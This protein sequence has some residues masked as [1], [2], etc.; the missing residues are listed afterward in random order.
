MADPFVVKDGDTYYL[1]AEAQYNSPSLDSAIVYYYSSDLFN[2]TYGGVVLDDIVAGDEHLSYPFVFKCDGEWY[3]I[4]DCQGDS[5]RLFKATNFPTSWKVYELMVSGNYQVRDATIFQWSSVWYL[6]VF[7]KDASTLR[8]YYS[9]YLYG[10]TW[11]EHPS[12]PILSGLD[13]SR[14]G[15]RPIIRDGT[16]VDI[17]LQDD[18]PSY[19]NALRIYRLTDLTT[20]TC[21]PTELGT[22]PILSASGSGWNASGMHTLDRIDSS[23]SI[24][25]GIGA[26]VWS[27]GIYRDSA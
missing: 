21:T 4:P 18:S 15:G 1:F 7:D 13:N 8:L 10:S 5:V 17:L 3:M 23:V 9:S 19:G 16:G 27:I 20:T 26:G 11:I 24:V 12:S 2:W 6:L 22:S 14:P 25:D